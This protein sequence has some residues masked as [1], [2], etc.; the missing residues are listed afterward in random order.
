MLNRKRSPLKSLS[1]RQP[2][3]SLDRKIN[4]IFYDKVLMPLMMVL[5]FFSVTVFEWF[6][7]YYKT[8]P[9]PWFM[10]FV[11][12]G[13]SMYTAIKLRKLWWEVKSLKLGREGE[14]IVGESLEELRVK[15]YKVFHDVVGENFNIDHVLVGS[16]GVFTV[17]TKTISKMMKGNP[18]ISYDGINIK[19]DG[20]TPDRDPIKQA[21]GQMFWLENFIAERAKLKIKVKPVVLYPGWYINQKS[22]DTEVWVLNEKSLPSFLNN[23]VVVL[24]QEQ[25]NLISSH[26]DSYMRNE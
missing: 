12:L 13:V 14:R 17:E 1:L 11:L 8:P 2:G 19:I 20:F 21:K 5:A 26:I 15:G 18:Q 23:G 22:L 3:Q 7:V 10:T 25:I 4:D 6:R 16:S 9:H 24:T